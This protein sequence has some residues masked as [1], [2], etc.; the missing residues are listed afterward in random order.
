M[1]AFSK[2]ALVTL[3]PWNASG[4]APIE[5]EVASIRP[6]IAPPT[7]RVNVGLRIDGAQVHISYFSLRDYVAM[8]YD[9]RDYQIS[10]PDWLT[11]QRFEISAT[12]PA[13]A[14][15]R[16]VPG[17]LTSLLEERFHLKAHRETK[18]FPIYALVLGKGELKLKESQADAGAPPSSATAVA[19]SGSQGGVTVNLG[20]GSSL[21]FANNRFEATKLT[22]ASFAEGIRRFMDRP[23]VDQ[24]ALTKAY[25]FTLTFTPED[26]NAMM[27]RS[28]VAAG[29]VL[30]P[31]VLKYMD[32][33]SG[34]SLFS[35]VEALGLKLDRRKAP[36][37]VVI[38]DRMEKL[39][40]EN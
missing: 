39:P 5:F 26:Y 29:V 21:T 35:A 28:A 38:V 36:L 37:E 15:R 32:T 3:L 10:G 23:V 34:D 4:Q 22:M 16:Q 6:S 18:D 25:D 31:E 19:A 2:I 20:N 7:D 1:N 33:A 17:M 14:S 11:S 12:L 27:I 9:V 30:P 8:A 24:T 40:S 13:G